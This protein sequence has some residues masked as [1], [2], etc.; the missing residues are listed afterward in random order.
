MSTA[1]ITITCDNALAA[2][3]M[4]WAQCKRLARR[5]GV[6]VMKLSHKCMVI[7]AALFLDALRKSK[8]Y[9]PAPVAA[10]DVD[11]ALIACG[12]KR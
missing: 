6:P 10:D 4:S 1:P 2:T 11:A 8:G 7:D 9:T 3:G 12:L 5:L